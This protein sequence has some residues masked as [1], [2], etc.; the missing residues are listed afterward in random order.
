MMAPQ[1]IAISNRNPKSYARPVGTALIEARR[2]AVSGKGFVPSA[3]TDYPV[4]VSFGIHP[5][6]HSSKEHHRR[7]HRSNSDAIPE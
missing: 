2:A 5:S 4:G 7:M 3:S 1:K 6:R